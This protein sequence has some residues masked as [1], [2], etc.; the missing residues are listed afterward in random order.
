MKPRDSDQGF[1]LAAVLVIIML[2]SMVAVSLIFRLK[3]EENA[4][5]AGA[6]SEQAWAAAMS[7]VREAMR[8]ATNVV[9]GSIAWQDNPRAF[10]DRFVFDDGSERWYF[11][12][13]SP[14]AGDSPGELR[15]GLN[16]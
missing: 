15:Y 5:A 12:V 13:C 16:R 4:T 9:P 8:I 1:V 10:R 7:G 2:V 6:G 3:A 11:T 14:V